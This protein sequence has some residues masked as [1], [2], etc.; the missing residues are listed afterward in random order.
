[1]DDTTTDPAF[2]PRYLRVDFHG[3]FQSLFV[4]SREEQDEA[5]R[6]ILDKLMEKFFS[7]IAPKSLPEID[8]LR[9]AAQVVNHE[10]VR[11]I[12]ESRDEATSDK[13]W[14]KIVRNFFKETEGMDGFAGV[15]HDDTTIFLEVTPT[16]ALLNLFAAF[17][18]D[19]S[20]ELVMDDGDEEPTIELLYETD[21]HARS[22]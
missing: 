2:P 21:E 4:R 13:P 9:H 10:R 5:A 19:G 1:M 14:N 7:K 6:S 3:R 11:I 12:L 18:V 17:N 15:Q 16:V 20:I 8:A 22:I